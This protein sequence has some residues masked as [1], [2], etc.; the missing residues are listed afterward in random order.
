MSAKPS[1]HTPTATWSAGLTGYFDHLQARRA[2]ASTIRTRRYDLQNLRAHLGAEETDAIEVSLDDLRQYQLG[3]LTGD[4]SRRGRPLSAGSVARLTATLRHFFAFLAAEGH[5]AADPAARLE[6]PRVP[7]RLPGAVLSVPEVKRLLGAAE[8]S[9]RGLRD[10]AMV[11]VFYATGVRRAELRNLDLC[12]LDHAE[13]TLLVRA[14]KG[15]KDRLLP[16][17]RSCYAGLTDYLRRGRPELMTRHPDSTRAV[18]L[19]ARG[20]R[21]SS[22][23]LADSLT[24][25]GRA[26]GINKRLTP[27]TLRRSCA[28]ALL[29][30]GVSLRHIQLLLGHA[31]LSITSVYLRLDPSDLRRELLLRHP[32]ERF[33]A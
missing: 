18:F 5:V 11:E 2:S 23:A 30:N 6:R 17:T 12:D 26:A 31:D 15:E 19:S 29:K 7:Q 13:R 28:T 27:H 33:E 20:Q 3:L 16:L 8:P 32:R 14:G 24:K 1:N 21:L 4:A 9:P 25:L 22:M 10:R